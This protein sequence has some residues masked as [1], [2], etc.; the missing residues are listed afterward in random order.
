MRSIAIIPARSGSKGLPN[1]NIKL[2]HGKPLLAYTI[3]AAIQSGCFA[4]IMVSTDSEKYAEIAREYGACVPFLRSKKTS[5]DTAS[6]WDMVEEVLDNY[7]ALN[8]VFESF[9]LLQ[10][11][12]PLRRG[13]DIKNAY[14]LFVC[15][16]A[17]AV[18]S[19]C[20]ADHSP[21]L[22]GKLTEDG[23]LSDFS[24]CNVPKR[25]QDDG[26][27]YRING[28]IYIASLPKFIQ[29]RNLYQKKSY[30]YVMPS[31]RSVDIDTDLDFRFVEFLLQKGDENV[32]FR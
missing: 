31:E 15:K 22:F 17:F 14:D 12:S 6:S 23:N 5:S 27:Y 21:T 8:K 30:A 16:K 9:C 19:V 26:V 4:E 25:R 2:L 1:K 28:A 20:E 7:K 24:I 11:T 32:C 18:V 29:D 3:E 10:P 13:D